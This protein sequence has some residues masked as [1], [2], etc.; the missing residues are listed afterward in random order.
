MPVYAGLIS[1]TPLLTLIPTPT[2]HTHTHLMPPGVQISCCPLAS[3]YDSRF[4]L[5]NLHRLTGRHTGRTEIGFTL[6]R[7]NFLDVCVP[8]QARP[9]VLML[10][11]CL[12]ISSLLFR[13]LS[14]LFHAGLQ[15]A[16]AVASDFLLSPWKECL[17]LPWWSILGRT[18]SLVS[19]QCVVCGFIRL[20]FRHWEP[21][22]TMTWESLHCTFPP[23]AFLFE[24][25]RHGC[26]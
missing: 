16:L 21:L 4:V 13:Q 7:S 19:V 5:L 6:E 22:P 26:F 14:S 20:Y 12:F 23:A 17:P 9:K 11:L 8:G 25:W 1:V 3:D 15:P 18:G 2:V 10:L 24:Q